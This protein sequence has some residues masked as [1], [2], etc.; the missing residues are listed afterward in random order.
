MPRALMAARRTSGEALLTIAAMAGAAETSP[1]WLRPSI[2]A[3]WTGGCNLVQHDSK[4]LG[5]VGSSHLAHQLKRGGLAG[6][7]LAEYGTDHQGQS[8]FAG[9]QRIIPR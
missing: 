4:G 3:T 2:K 1:R 7:V 8:L 5:R 9:G 6:A